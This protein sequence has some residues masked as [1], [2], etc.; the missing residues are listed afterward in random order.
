MPT[1]TFQKLFAGVDC[2]HTLWA[3][4]VSEHCAPSEVNF[5]SEKVVI[6]PSNSNNSQGVSI[7]NSSDFSGIQKSIKKGFSFSETVLVE[8]FVCGK[9]INVDGLMIDG[10]FHL[11]SLTERNDQVAGDVVSLW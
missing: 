2:P 8:Q 4:N 10:H 5:E 9:Q 11:I 1:N 7:K 6:K 3:G